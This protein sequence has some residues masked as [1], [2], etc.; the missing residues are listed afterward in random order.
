MNA[1]MN[2]NPRRSRKPITN[3]WKTVSEGV[4]YSESLKLYWANGNVYDELS[5]SHNG[6]IGCGLRFREI[7]KEEQNG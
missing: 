7:M 5:A 6:I 2:L 1:S 4:E 3:D